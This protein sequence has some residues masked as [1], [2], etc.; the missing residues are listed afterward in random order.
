MPEIHIFLNS[1]LTTAKAV[2]EILASGGKDAKTRP[3][4]PN[5]RLFT[6]LPTVYW[7]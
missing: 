6:H 1:F 2:H 7:G 4:R 5:E 3:T